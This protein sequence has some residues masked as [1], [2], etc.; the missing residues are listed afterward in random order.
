MHAC[1][2][3]RTDMMNHMQNIFIENAKSLGQLTS[4]CAQFH[5]RCIPQKVQKAMDRGISACEHRDRRDKLQE[6]QS[7]G[8]DEAECIMEAEQLK[9]LDVWQ[10]CVPMPKTER[11]CRAI[12]RQVTSQLRTANLE[13]QGVHTHGHVHT[14]TTYGL[15]TAHIH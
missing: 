2:C 9:E 15:H 14:H 3:P 8:R 13:S 12:T 1:I 10:T 11:A 4:K 7:I 6:K 5:A